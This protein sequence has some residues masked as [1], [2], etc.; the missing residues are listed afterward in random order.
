MT[1]SSVSFSRMSDSISASSSDILVR[2]AVV[3]VLV[4][5]RDGE[6]TGGG[7]SEGR[8][9]GAMEVGEMLCRKR[10]ERVGLRRM[11]DG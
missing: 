10:W 2:V 4:M 1:R 9:L 5:V 11:K 7:V 6:K 3:L 8:G